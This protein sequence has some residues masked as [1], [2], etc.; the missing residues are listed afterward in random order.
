MVNSISF[1]IAVENIDEQESRELIAELVEEGSLSGEEDESVEGFGY[2]AR[3][4]GRE[5]IF[6]HSSADRRLT[7]S[8]LFWDNNP[9]PGD[10]FLGFKTIDMSIKTLQNMA[11]LRDEIN[12]ITDNKVV[13][14]PTNDY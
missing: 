8:E 10:R 3:Y 9:K 1:E 11:N 5:Y 2:I 7:T 14:G 4:D 12:E 13:A 6:S